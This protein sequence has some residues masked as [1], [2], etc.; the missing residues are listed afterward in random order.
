MFDRPK[1][2][3]GCKTCVFPWDADFCK[4]P[5]WHFISINLV[6][7]KFCFLFYTIY[8]TNFLFLIIITMQTICWDTPLP[9]PLTRWPRVV[10]DKMY[11]PQKRWVWHFWQGGLFTNMQS[12]WL[13]S[14]HAMMTRLTALLG[15][16]SQPSTSSSLSSCITSYSCIFEIHVGI[17]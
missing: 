4:S 3:K 9:P 8:S 17:F 2:G 12:N 16:S 14:L 13:R 10:R 6:S 11:T 15:H 5:I 7:N 1:R